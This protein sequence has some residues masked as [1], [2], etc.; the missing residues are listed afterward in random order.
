[1]CSA[2]WSPPPHAEIKEQIVKNYLHIWF[3]MLSKKPTTLLYIDGFAGPGIY[4]N[5][6]RGSPII[7]MEEAALALSREGHEKARIL[8][9]F[10]EK[11]QQVADGL[12]H[13]VKKHV[14]ELRN[15][16]GDSVVD[17]I[18]IKIRNK[19]FSLVIENLENQY[20]NIEKNPAF[21]FL[22]PFG[23]A[24]SGFSFEWLEKI[25]KFRKGEFLLNFYVQGI[26]RNRHKL[27]QQKIAQIFGE[28]IDISNITVEGMAGLFSIKIQSKLNMK[29]LLYEMNNRKN[30][31]L[32]YLVFA[33]KHSS[34]VKKMK[35]V[36]RRLSGKEL[37][38]TNEG[39]INQF[40]LF[41][42][43]GIDQF[44][45]SFFEV[46]NGKSISV[47]EIF[48]YYATSNDYVWTEADI[49]HFLKELERKGK[50]K[51]ENV[52]LNGRKRRRGTFPPDAL[53]RVLQP[54]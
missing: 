10:I 16:Y 14:V 35:E 41:E 20:S 22:D 34:G 21:V 27:S 45:E 51:V 43:V 47:R 24:R 33:T 30:R 54:R 32:Y 6:M 49:R 2:K 53:V 23:L 48:E 19:D 1:M 28:N 17:R 9:V 50:I 37:H 31:T 52:K 46:F 38:F 7:A 15:Q 40:R 42:T 39:Y 3:T 36:M 18:S 11:D 13:N 8:L 26:E 44:E 29:T 25:A 4:E 12:R 5:G